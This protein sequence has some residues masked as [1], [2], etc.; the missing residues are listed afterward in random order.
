MKNSTF[1]LKT[2]HQVI[3][4][5]NKSFEKYI[6]VE[7]IQ[8]K[9]AL[10]A[11]EINADFSQ[12]EVEFISILDGS[13]MF[14]SDLFKK[15]NLQTTISFLK[16]KSYE[17][18]ESTGKINE[19]IGL[20]SIITGKHIVIIEDII[21]TGATMDY[22]VET[23]QKQRPASISIATLM[24]KPNAFKGKFSPKYIGFKISNEFIVG[25][26]MD[27]DGYGRNLESIYQ[28]KGSDPKIPLC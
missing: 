25:Y 2:K 17:A 5:L 12:K 23:L 24:F 22:V 13:F 27:F 6:S 4:I 9:V 26:G 18:T 14:A 21:D 11:Q 16:I 3:E 15:I 8:E 19:L 1:A 28:I 20:Q 10:L 7:E